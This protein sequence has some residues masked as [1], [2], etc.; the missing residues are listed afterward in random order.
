[1]E[2]QEVTVVLQKDLTHTETQ[3]LILKNAELGFLRMT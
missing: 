3:R 2:Q 1:M